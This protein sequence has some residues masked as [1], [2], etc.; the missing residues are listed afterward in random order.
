MSTTLTRRT[1][2]TLGG[3]TVIY[4]IG[5]RGMPRADA[6]G[7]TGGRAELGGP[8]IAITDRNELLVLVDK[9]E[10]GQGIRHL[11]ASIVARE[12]GSAPETITVEDA[13]VDA[14]RYA[15]RYI[16]PRVK[17]LPVG[18]FLKFQ[19]TGRSSSVADRWD[20]LRDAAV[21]ARKT[22][23]KKAATRLEASVDRIELR[24]CRAFVRG[25][26][27]SASLA[28][29][30]GR[31]PSLPDT[32]PPV[33]LPAFISRIP[34]ASRPRIDAWAKVTGQARFGI[35]VGPEDLER[36]GLRGLRVLVAL[37]LRPGRAGDTIAISNQSAIESMPGVT[38]VVPI[39]KGGG[40]AVVA[41]SFWHADRARCAMK[42][43]VTPRGGPRADSAAILAA[44]ERALAEEVKDVPDVRGP[45]RPIPW[46]NYVTPFGAHAA[47]EPLSATCVKAP[48][49]LHIYAA[50][51]FP[52]SARAQA[53]SAFGV[54]EG[55]VVMHG[56]L[57]GGAFGR[58]AASDFIVEAAEVCKALSDRGVGD[59]VKLMWTR[60]D[61]FRHDYLRPCAVSR[62]RAATAPD[63]TLGAWQHLMVSESPNL[64]MQHDYVWA[65]GVLRAAR[66]IGAD[67]AQPERPNVDVLDVTLKEEGLK[68][69]VYEMKPLVRLV[70]V[71][72]AEERLHATVRIGYWRSVGLFHTL[73][74]VESTIDELAAARGSNPLDIRLR[75]LR[76]AGARQ[77]RLLK[78]V[79]DVAQLVGEDRIRQRRTGYGM[80]CFSG[81]DSFAALVVKVTTGNDGIRVSDAWAVVDCGYVVNPDVLAQQ[82][83]GGII[84]GLSAALKGEIT[85]MNGVVQQTNFHTCDSLRIDECPRIQVVAQ[86]YDGPTAATPTGV[87][88]LMVPLP[89]PAVANAVFNLTDRRLRRL[90][91]DLG[92]PR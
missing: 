4:L 68:D 33:E 12:L 91:L 36:D 72:A 27:K 8:W 89:A 48:D 20:R 5:A 49:G 58:R 28:A 19:M 53:A 80:A 9:C 81:W 90:P 35:D 40:V 60:E 21:E 23:T 45:N 39:G 22:L 17:G 52:D 56:L 88:E 74:A 25:T 67:W 55:R 34:A 3:A 62:V 31:G 38:A 77:K 6:A 13:P 86:Q 57:A 44:Y 16:V 61:D 66:W 78:C 24:Q 64:A 51:Q 92:A 7:H 69:S 87:G 41:D 10:M 47:M 11:F 32:T 83:E 63:L 29:L 82:V 73:F 14:R 84:F 76:R 26:E 30:L 1:F 50:S 54:E 71:P 79:T 2:L 65:S 85:T 18:K 70:K 37:V 59:A 15:N 42:E 43:Q 46:E 75:N